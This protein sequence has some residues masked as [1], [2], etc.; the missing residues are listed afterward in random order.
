[1]KEENKL[2]GYKASL[3]RCYQ[4]KKRQEVFKGC[5][6]GLEKA[7]FQCNRPEYASQFK[8][9]LKELVLF[10]EK[11]HKGGHDI[12]CILCEIKDIKLTGP[13]KPPTTADEYDR[14]V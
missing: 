2:E 7:V 10:V 5:E 8:T 13:T 12:G 14:A 4:A 3:G 9:T 1:M 6:E 11:E